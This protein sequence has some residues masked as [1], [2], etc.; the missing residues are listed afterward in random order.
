MSTQSSTYGESR[1]RELTEALNEERQQVGGLRQLNE[2]MQVR[3]S[4]LLDEAKERK[5]A[6][7]TLEMDIGKLVRRYADLESRAVDLDFRIQE[8]EE[9]FRSQ[10]NS[11]RC[12]NIELEKR[13]TEN[14]EQLEV[15][16]MS[17]VKE[18]RELES[19]LETCQALNE[20]L[21]EELDRGRILQREGHD[22]TRKLQEHIESLKN[23]VVTVEG[24]RD[25]KSRE[26]IVQQSEMDQLRTDLQ[27]ERLAN[28]QQREKEAELIQ[29]NDI[30]Q[31]HWQ[32]LSERKNHLE[33]TSK[34]L[35]NTIGLL[36]EQKTQLSNACSKLGSDFE[37]SKKQILELT[38]AREFLDQALN[39][40]TK[41]KDDQIKA[42]EEQVETLR[43]RAKQYQRQGSEELT[44]LLSMSLEEESTIVGIFCITIHSGEF[45]IK[46]PAKYPS[47][48]IERVLQA[49][50]SLEH[51][52][53]E[54]WAMLCDGEVLQET[55]SRDAGCIASIIRKKH[56]FYAGPRSIIQATSATRDL[57]RQQ[58]QHFQYSQD[59]IIRPR[60][61][62]ELAQ[63]SAGEVHG[64]GKQPALAGANRR[65]EDEDENGDTRAV[66]HGTRIENIAKEPGEGSELAWRDTFSENGGRRMKLHHMVLYD[67]QVRD[68]PDF[69]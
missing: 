42:L 49:I 1:L 39:S 6:L 22:E 61:R 9:L 2:E 46:I 51:N 21:N 10:N 36:Q 45:W 20:Q 44:E 58:S 64:D 19:Q 17:Y 26:M 31:R 43:R 12:M 37:D 30:F 59:Q 28:E 8:G 27:N 35:N 57:Q 7:R 33:L 5:H 68:E 56:F 24:S 69:T 11:L 41:I 50:T 23:L 67:S 14:R 18:K 63:A 55:N 13:I 62:K 48:K 65:R 25:V 4:S 16:N 3:I 47:V 66:S 52:G 29:R 40:T 38:D 34:E 60:K 15:C 53:P 54:P 32:E